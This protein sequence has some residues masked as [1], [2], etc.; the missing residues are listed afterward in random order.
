MGLQDK[1]RDMMGQKA[2]EGKKF[3]EENGKRPE[4]VTLPSGLQYEILTE[5]EGPKPGP[6]SMVT[7][8]YEGRLTNGNVF[9]SSYKRN[10]PATFGVHQVISGWTEGLQ[11]MS[12]GS[13]WRLYIPS[14]LGYG[15]R[16]AGGAIPPHSALIFD[17]ELIDF[18]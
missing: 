16:G 9:D 11:L 13:K 18:R 5:G 2:E 12:K 3:L 17:V 1:L 15:S 14:E 8:H 10:Q 7:V 4:V 6:T